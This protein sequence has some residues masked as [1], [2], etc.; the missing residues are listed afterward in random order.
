V[1]QE[2]GSS[3]IQMT[4][5]YFIFFFFAY[6]E[7]SMLFLYSFCFGNTWVWTQSFTPA[8]QGLYGWPTPLV[9]FCFG[10]LDRV[11]YFFPRWALEHNP[12]SYAFCIVLI[13]DMYHYTWLVSLDGVVKN[14]LSGLASNHDFPDLCLPSSWN[15]RCVLSHQAPFY[16]FQVYDEVTSDLVHLVL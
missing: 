2:S 12:P 5:S 7:F 6:F 8:K 16:V 10:Y 3:R 14:F 15:Y 11:L 9:L 4:L 1:T 13:I